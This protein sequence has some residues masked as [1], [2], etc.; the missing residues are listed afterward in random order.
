MH[1]GLLRA[2]SRQEQAVWPFLL[3]VRGVVVAR[4]KLE[5]EARR[6]GSAT[7]RLCSPRRRRL[8]ERRPESS[9]GRTMAPSRNPSTTGTPSS[10]PSPPAY[11]DLRDCALPRC[12]LAA[13]EGSHPGR[14]SWRFAARHI[15]PHRLRS[16]PRGFR[17]RRAWSRVLARRSL[18]RETRPRC[19][20]ETRDSPRTPL[21]R[22]RSLPCRLARRASQPP[23][24]SRTPLP[25]ALSAWTTP[26][27]TTAARFGRPSIAP[28]PR[29]SPQT[30]C[31]GCA[32]WTLSTRRAAH[33]GRGPPRAR[34]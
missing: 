9:L 33:P 1:V 12:P 32:D 11:R 30:T 13:P 18:G 15:R 10:P 27:A 14:R 34:L 3:T 28:P 16:P 24:L 26:P 5:R 29:R 23:P 19:T 20:E 25:P 8:A 17:P 7:R 22:T 2:K 21:G 6:P 31:T 4:A